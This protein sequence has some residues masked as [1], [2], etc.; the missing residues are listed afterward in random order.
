MAVRAVEPGHALIEGF[1]VAV[2]APETEQSATKGSALAVGAAIEGSSLWP[3]EHPLA[4]AAADVELVVLQRQ[5]VTLEAALQGAKRFGGDRYLR[6]TLKARLGA[7][8]KLCA[9]LGDP[10]RMHLR[11]IAMERDEK[12]KVARA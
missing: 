10:T 1:V 7:V 6:E 4:R 9:Q 3:G 5:Q 11:A 8:N 2:R 12:V